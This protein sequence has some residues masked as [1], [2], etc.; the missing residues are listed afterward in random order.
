MKFF[1]MDI[2]TVWDGKDLFCFQ[3]EVYLKKQISF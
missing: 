3:M 1:A 2:P